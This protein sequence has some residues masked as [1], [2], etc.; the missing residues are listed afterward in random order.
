[1]TH[2]RGYYIILFSGSPNESKVWYPKKKKALKA[3]VDLFSKGYV[4]GE[5][6][7]VKVYDLHKHLMGED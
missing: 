3:I 4:A 6:T 2:L 7:F 5:I 1:M